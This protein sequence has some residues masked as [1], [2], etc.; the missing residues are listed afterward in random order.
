MQSEMEITADQIQQFKHEGYLILEDFFDDREKAAMVA[1]LNRF[2]RDGLGRN[3]S[4][5]GDG[6]TH[7]NTK[8]NYQ[9]IPLNNKSDLYRALPWCPKVKDTLSKLIGDPYLRHL[10]Q[11]FFKPPHTGAGTNWHQDNGYFKVSDPTKAT[12]MWIALHDASIENGTMHIEPGGHKKAY[13]HERDPDSDHHITCQ[14]D[15]ENVIAVEMKAGGV[16]FFNYGIPHC[17]KG[18]TT[19]KPRAGCAYHFLRTDFIPEHY[20]WEK[21]PPVITG[22]DATGGEREYGVRIEG[23]W[24]DEVNKLAG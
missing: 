2:V 10:D 16:L 20:K 24:D 1:E 15:E 19:D 3:V 12:G 8:T 22:P 4:T 18:N 11:I 13:D 23:T 5:D 6:K 9:I 17:T 14:P 7:S 21:L